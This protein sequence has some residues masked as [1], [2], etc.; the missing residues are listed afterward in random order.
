MG[1]ALFLGETVGWRRWTATLVGLFGVLLII[2]PG[3]TS[4]EPLSLLALIGVFGLAMRAIATRRAP[5]SISSMQLSY[6]GFFATVPAGLGLLLFSE[7]PLSA[8]SPNNLLTFAAAMLVGLFAYYA[9]VAAMRV[10]EVSFVS[11]FRYIRLLFAMVIGITV[12]SETIDGLTL[13]GAAIIVASGIYTVWR[14]RKHRRS[15]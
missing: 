1:A 9:I 11:P 8:M 3:M 13:L 7:T 2:R 14:E 5:P 12:F 6:L 15:T 4:F 10:G